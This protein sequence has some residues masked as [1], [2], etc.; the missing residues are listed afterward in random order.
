MYVEIT[1]MLSNLIEMQF[2][3]IEADDDDYIDLVSA[4]LA[5]RYYYI[6]GNLVV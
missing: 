5:Q 4:R 3:K 6:I 1:C 2:R